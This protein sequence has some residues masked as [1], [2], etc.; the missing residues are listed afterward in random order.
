MRL[1]GIA[2]CLALLSLALPARALEPF[3]APPVRSGSVEVRLVQARDV[4]TAEPVLVTFGM[5]FPRGSVTEAQL[6]LVR[7][8]RDGVEVPAFVEQLTPWRHRF[9]AAQDGTSVRV[10]RI[11]IR[12]RFS[13]S[14]PETIE[15]HWG[16]P[17]RTRSLP[18][19][20]D[21]RSA[22]HVV[23]SGSFGAAD[24]ISEP[25]VYAVLP[26]HWLSRGLLKP[27]RST[28]LHASIGEAR[29][30]PAAMDAIGSWDGF[31]ESERAFKNNFYS[32]INRDDARVTASNR[33]QYKTDREPW[34][35]DRSATMFVLYFRSGFPTAL[36]EAVQAAQ[37]YAANLDDRG[38]FRLAPGDAKYAYN[39]S[40]AYSFWLTGDDRLGALV[41]RVAGAHDATA[42]VWTPQRGFW[43]ERHTAYKL[44]AQVVS[45]E[46]NGGT[47]RRD[48]VERTLADLRTHQDGANGD[49]PANRIDGGL[50]HF[51]AQHDG[52]WADDRLGASSWMSA[53]LSDAAVRA[54]AS[55]GDPATARFVRRLGNFLR[56]SI[57]NTTEHS[58]DT[59]PG[60]LALPRYAVLLEGT[61]GQRNPEDIEHALDVAGQLGWAW[62]F[63]QV[64]GAPDPALRDAAVALYRSYDAGVN[65]WIRPAGPTAGL[66]AFRVSPWRKWGWEHRTSDG[67]AFTLGGA[68]PV[69]ARSS[70]LFAD[71]AQDGHG[72]VLHAVD[73]GARVVAS[74]FTYL[75]GEPRWFSGVGDVVGN[76]VSIPMTIGAGGD[77]P[78][79]FSSTQVRTAPWG[80][81]ELEYLDDDQVGLSWTSSQ[82][83][84]L[85]GTQVLRRISQPASDAQAPALGI[86][87]CHQGAWFD[88]SQPGH[89]M[90]VELQGQP[91]ARTLVL[92]WYAYLEGQPRWLLGAGP[93]DGAT[94]TLT[95]VAPTGADFQPRFLP[96]RVVRQPWGQLRFTALGADRARVDWDSTLPGYGSGS[97][98]LT[99]AYGLAGRDCG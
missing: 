84:F 90:V 43:T 81:L 60:R 17:A 98:A 39:E 89:G 45:W 70:G 59:A 97:L 29:D 94:A 92:L 82:S 76:R 93:V 36:R 99:R 55:G 22:W 69:G 88:P 32:V 80:T 66:A 25:D 57:V 86:V 28:P 10:A 2:L 30:D 18:T 20:T 31:Q 79:R 50:Y 64:L 38:F 53:L 15:V 21:P 8:L 24:G 23:D 19:L 61:D 63:S 12:H 3:V 44:L 42:H 85:A 65:H 87:P 16:G 14:G 6:A 47:A 48:A 33:V 26:A 46:V 4:G 77:F 34:L 37:F 56:A 35:Y 96:S 62:Y 73:G 67:I 95:V 54:Y 52:D 83:G 7:V 91:G 72:L 41:A 78:P 9:D 27:S 49:I 51:G 71:P 40:L 5:P 68:G 75:S 1:A 11:Q 58:Y 13:G 74:W